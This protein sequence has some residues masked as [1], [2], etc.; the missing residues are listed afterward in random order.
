MPTYPDADLQRPVGVSAGLLQGDVAQGG[1]QRREH[2]R[3]RR[4]PGRRG[5]QDGHDRLDHAQP[6]RLRG[7]PAR[8]GRRGRQVLHLRG[9]QDLADRARTTSTS[10]SPI[11]GPACYEY[12]LKCELEG[13]ARLRRLAII[14]DVQMAPLALPEMV[15]GENAFTYT[16]QS[17]GDRKVRITHHWVERSASQA[18][19]GARR[20]RSTRP[21]A[22]RPTARTSSS[23]GRLPTIPT[24]TRSP[25]TTSS[26]PA[27]PT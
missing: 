11:V 18:A 6:L 23:N 8:G 7:R 4:R 21:T 19:A 10:S 15:V 22:A 5:G 26:C 12:Q 20:P 25:T 3:R 27:A 17:A 16:D 13:P 1:R 9:R 14:N 24:A 2:R